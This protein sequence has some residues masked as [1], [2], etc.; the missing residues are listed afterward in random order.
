[1]ADPVL[2]PNPIENGH[3]VDGEPLKEKLKRAVDEAGRVADEVGE[4]VAEV[5]L[6]TAVGALE[7]R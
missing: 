3:V 7:S 2:D 4:V 1:M 5:G 6:E